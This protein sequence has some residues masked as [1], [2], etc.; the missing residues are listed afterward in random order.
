MCG[1]VG[2]LLPNG[3]QE[4]AN[5]L[6][7]ACD[8]MVHRGPDDEGLFLSGPVGLGFRRLSIL[9]LTA[10][11]H[12]PMT[13]ADGEW[14]VVFNGEIYN[15]I[16]LRRELRAAGRVLRSD[17][18]TEVLVEG[19]SLWGLRIFERCNGMWAVLAWHGPTQTL[20]V[21]RDPWGI[22][23]LLSARLDGGW[24]FASEISALRALGCQLGEF[25]LQVASH[26]LATGELDIADNTAFTAVRR[27]LPGRVYVYRLGAD[28]FAVAYADGTAQVE[29]PHHDGSEGADRDYVAAFRAAYTRSVEARNR[30]DVPVGTCLS[31]GLDSTSIAC[32]AARAQPA[33]RVQ[34]CRYAFSA[35]IPEFDETPYIKAVVEQTQ[36]NWY[37][38]VCEDSS[39]TS[40][41]DAF[42]ASN[43]EPMHSLSAFAG[44]LVMEL[45]ARN[46]V[47]VLL[48]GQGADELLAGYSSS[49]QP[50]LRTVAATE[51]LVPALKAARSESTGQFGVAQTALRM[52]GGLVMAALPRE[53]QIAMYRR[54][55]ESNEVPLL[56]KHLH[57][58]LVASADAHNFL[59]ANLLDQQIRAPLPLYLRIEDTNSSAFSLESRLPFLDP[60]V[61]ALARAAPPRLLR[62]N[63]L[64][65]Y[66]LRESLRGV[67]PEVVRTRKDKMGFP[68]PAERWWRGPLGDRM[69]HLLTPERLSR[70]GL[71]DVP[72]LMAAIHAYWGGAKLQPWLGRVFNL[73]LWAAH[74]IDGGR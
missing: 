51:G 62:R 63:G 65:K 68:I 2:V 30:S 27:L 44:Y 34:P 15:F 54:R 42:V 73:E 58:S 52:G 35:L 36:I 49:A 13:S 50:Y 31:G 10:A 38:T 40:R 69:R 12:Q 37:H 61:V 46:G 7:R 22:K 28:P 21:C 53:R 4:R 20:Y 56:N 33:E 8:A 23:P 17:S 5:G 16:E 29:I 71:Y 74:H 67:V 72:S 70:R 9:D 24:A 59:A 45:A 6:R 55:V 19:L 43:G 18:D 64:N 48:N 32:I 11:G 1:L 57:P 14:T 3:A 47:K 60:A 25:N 26:F 39:V 66:L 41:I